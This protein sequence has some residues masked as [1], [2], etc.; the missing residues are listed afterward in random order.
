[1]ATDANDLQPVRAGKLHRSPR[2]CRNVE[3]GVIVQ[4]GNIESPPE[5]TFTLVVSAHGALLSLRTDAALGGAL[6][7]RKVKTKE[8]VSCRIVGCGEKKG[9]IANVGVQFVDPRAN[10]WQVAFP[11]A[12]WSPRSAEAKLYRPRLV[13]NA[14]AA[15]T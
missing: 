3:V 8:D 15:K 12:D 1:V 7:V 13:T 5:R 4:R 10:F 14:P 6:T 11:P 9:D 2:V